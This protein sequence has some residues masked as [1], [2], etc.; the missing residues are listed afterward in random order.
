[1][2]VGNPIMHHLFLGIDPTELG[3]APFALAASAALQFPA[4]DIG[5]A[6]APGARVYTLPCIA[7][8]VGADAAGATL[9]EAPH[10]SEEITLLVDI[11]TNA[12]I[13]LGSSKRLVAA[14]SPTG[15]A[16][17]GA[18]ITA[19][20]RAAPGAIERVRIDPV[21]LEPR[22]RV[23]GIEPWSDQPGF[24]EQAETLGVTGICGSA[25]IEVVAEMYLAGIINE[26]GVV[27]GQLAE[28]SDR[29]RSEGRTFSYVLWRGAQ[30]HVITQNDVRAIQLAKAALYAGVKLLMDKLGITAVD[31]IKLAGAFGTFIDPK[32]A[33]V[34]GLIP[35]CD[36]AK[37]EGVGNAAGTGARMALLNRDHRREIEELV[38]RIE[39]I[40][41]A[42]EPK[43]QEHFVYAMAVPNKVDAFP[44]LAAAVKLPERSADAGGEPVTE[45]RRRRRR[46]PARPPW[47]AAR[48]RLRS[49]RKS[50]TQSLMRWCGSALRWSNGTAAAD[51][52]MQSHHPALSRWWASS[53]VAAYETSGSRKPEVISTRRTCGLAPTMA[54][55]EPCPCNVRTNECRALAAVEIDHRDVADVE[56]Q[57][58]RIAADA[59][60]SEAQPR[61]AT[62]EQDAGDL[63]D[64]EV[65][66]DRLLLFLAVRMRRQQ[67]ALGNL[68]VFSHPL[69]E[70]EGAEDDADADAHGKVDEDGKEE[71]RQQ[72][73]RIAAR[74]LQ[75]GEE[76]VPLRHVPGDDGE[77]G[78]ERRKR[79]V[80]GKRC[81]HHHEQQQVDR[82]QHAGYRRLGAGTDIGGGA[83][84]GAGNRNAAEYDRSDIGDPL[85][86]QFAVGAV[87]AAAH[88]VGDDGAQ[89]QLD[90]RQQG[91]REG[92]R[93]Q[94]L[95]PLQVER[96]QRR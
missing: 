95:H 48:R 26:D 51:A 18:Q 57:H 45:R 11:G 75:Q 62:E 92:V 89:Q 77:D 64:H 86:D 37:V 70:Q 50:T 15:P 42:L 28:R 46:R 71:C 2:F 84:D 74:R 60:E 83:G 58:L 29:I 94:L 69:H 27:R 43:F 55:R 17:E 67:I 33:M 34:L 49:N 65:G 21:T 39:K 13:V 7:G 32:Y 22:V 91:D 14:S 47:W 31:R 5:L 24:A 3:G 68:D 40:E 52:M 81:R 96:R 44:H 78:A 25:I 36:L 85:A 76:L 10:K 59:V 53:M 12:E 79:N 16:F 30:E 56:H 38:A 23:I 4:R 61:G 80:G 63:V 66:I 9:A 73:D 90:G 88:A 41:T 87:A 6:I 54:T 93:Q 1:M 19:G 72:H 20:Q 35:D 82:V 8:H